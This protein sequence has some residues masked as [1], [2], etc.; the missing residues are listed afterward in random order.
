MKP[1]WISR[2]VLLLAFA[3]A[4][5]PAAHAA[6]VGWPFKGKRA[7]VSAASAATTPSGEASVMQAAAVRAAPGR[8]TWVCAP[9]GAGRK[10]EC[11]RR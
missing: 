10:S 7:Q 6:E 9:A 1:V 11:A 2:G 3:A 5:A 8:G 4:S